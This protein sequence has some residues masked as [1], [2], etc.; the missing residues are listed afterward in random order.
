MGAYAMLTESWTPDVAEQNV[1]DAVNWLACLDEGGL[2]SWP[3]TM[4]RAEIE[5]ATDAA[6]EIVRPA[7]V[8]FSARWSCSDD[9]R[10]F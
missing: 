8:T 2:P 9:G 4:T 3:T 5:A 7:F 1:A 6:R 10:V